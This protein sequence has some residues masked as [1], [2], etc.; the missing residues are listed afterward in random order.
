MVYF[1]GQLLLMA[2]I[3]ISESAQSNV[4]VSSCD[5]IKY[6]MRNQLISSLQEPCRF[7]SCCNHT[8]PCCWET[9]VTCDL[10]LMT[11]AQPMI[12][13]KSFPF[14]VMHVIYY[15]KNVIAEGR[16]VQSCHI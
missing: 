12:I 3:N 8:P 16:H 5:M 10:I 15:N 7:G 11:G 14:P 1:C 9:K 2:S 13:I 4:I 6:N